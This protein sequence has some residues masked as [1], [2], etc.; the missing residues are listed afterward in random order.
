MNLAK[1]LLTKK[2]GNAIIEYRYV[3]CRVMLAA[4]ER[5]FPCLWGYRLSPI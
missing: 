2:T 4:T 1:I 5:K 3:S